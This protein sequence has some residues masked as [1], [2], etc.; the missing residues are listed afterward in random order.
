MWDNHQMYMVGYQTIP[1]QRTL[2]KP[3]VPSQQIQ[4]DE[5]I[6]IGVENR[7]LRISTLCDVVRDTFSNDAREP[8]HNT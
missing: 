8:G 5:P 6:G 3:R 1:N 2:V 4:I 7:T